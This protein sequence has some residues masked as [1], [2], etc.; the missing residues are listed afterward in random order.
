MRQNTVKMTTAQ[1][2]ELHGVNRRT[3]HYYDDIG[4]FS[5]C[6]KGENG[7][8]YY[9]ASQSIVFEYIRMLKEL[10]MSIAEIADY[11][12]HPAPEKFLQIA[13]RK[14]AEIDLEIRRLKRARNILKTKKAQVRLC[15]GLPDEEIRVEA[16]GAVKIS[17]LPYDFS[18]DDLSRLFTDLKSQWGIEQI[19]MGIG[20][21]LSLDKVTAGSFETYDGLFTYS[22]GSASGPHTFVS[23]R[24]GTL[25]LSEGTLGQGARH[26][27]KNDRLCPPAAS[28]TD[29]LCLR[30]WIE[31][32]CDLQP[33]GIRHKIHDPDR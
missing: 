32:I 24:G 10:N 9:D 33:G 30:A 25:R 4:L 17:V 14:E 1:F 15:E 23:R 26:V 5:P 12:K 3:L 27:P 18:G 6:Q 2:A 16:C 20:S 21:F 31:R 29:G 28:D 13:D 19:R 8:R 7:Y 11:C 22:S